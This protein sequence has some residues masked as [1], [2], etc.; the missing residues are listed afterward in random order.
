MLP[1]SLLSTT[2]LLLLRSHGVSASD[3][4][5]HSFGKIDSC[6]NGHPANVTSFDI[7]IFPGNATL[8]FSFSG[9]ATVPGNAT[10]SVAVEADGDEVYRAQIDPCSVGIP[11]LCPATGSMA[12]FANASMHI[13]ADTLDHMDLASH[14]DVR[15]R[16]SLQTY[17]VYARFHSSCV[18]T[19]L[20]FDS[21]GDNG[22]GTAGAE[23]SGSGNE[24]DGGKDSNSTNGRADNDG[25]GTS[26]N[27]GA[28]TLQDVG[29]VAM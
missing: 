16:L 28:S 14:A 22:N 24:T 17:D 25:L 3:A 4:I 26:Q 21:S 15:G 10:L 9:L 8:T 12:S 29:Y 27:S 7:Y 5:Y 2:A 1:K 11:D 18:E 20:R 23:G 6:Q 13:P 19:A